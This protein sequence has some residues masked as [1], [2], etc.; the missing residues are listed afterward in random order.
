MNSRRLPR[1]LFLTDAEG[2]PPRNDRTTTLESPLASI[3][4]R[5]MRLA[6]VEA[7][8]AG[9]A[10]E[11]PIGAVA[12]AHGKVVARGQNRSIRDSDPTAHAEIV[13]L[14]CAARRLKNYRLNEIMLFVTIEPCA[15][16]AGATIWARV[17]K[18]VY[19]APDPKAGACG[20]VVN[21][22]GHPAFN[23]HPQIIG[24]VLAPEC[25]R[26][27]QHFFRSKRLIPGKH[28]SWQCQRST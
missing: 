26:L 19:G 27:L 9:R 23:H 13:A 5:F 15:M 28:K 21:V 7:R 25:R 14:R 1:R 10:G 18:V 11:V 22:L 8:A 24:G 6:L 4:E 20:S 16:C 3:S 17:E 12:V 2:Q